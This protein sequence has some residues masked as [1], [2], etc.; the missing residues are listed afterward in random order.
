VRTAV[1]TARPLIA[2]RQKPVDAHRNMAEHRG[3]SLSSLTS[4]VC[5]LREAKGLFALE[6]RVRRSVGGEA[7][8]LS[9][10]LRCRLETREQCG[11]RRITSA[12]LGAHRFTSRQEMASG[13][14]PRCYPG[15]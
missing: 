13:L 3:T 5:S 4:A 15:A 6:A 7:V 11:R 14:L 8:D 2:E 12:S 10:Y 9:I 1:R